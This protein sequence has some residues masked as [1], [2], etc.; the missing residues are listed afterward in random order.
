MPASVEIHISWKPS[1][2]FGANFPMRKWN[3]SSGP[4]GESNCMCACSSSTAT[5]PS[6]CS[7]NV[8][9]LRY[10]TCSPSVPAPNTFSFLRELQIV[11]D[12]VVVVPSS[13]SDEVFTSASF[14]FTASGTALD[15]SPGHTASGH[16]L[17]YAGAPRL[18]GGSLTISSVSP[19]MRYPRSR[20]ASPNAF[21]F[22]NTM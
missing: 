22:G 4:N 12:A 15:I 1:T 13:L 2:T 20:N 5:V 3:R 10:E 9:S 19:G 8:T 6:G 7:P 17:L 16:S 21:S 18:T 14:T 11:P